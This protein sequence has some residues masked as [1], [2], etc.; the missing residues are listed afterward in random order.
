MAGPRAEREE[1]PEAS[2]GGSLSERSA[3][4]GASAEEDEDA[5]E[6]DDSG[7]QTAARSAAAARRAR[8]KQARWE[9]RQAAAQ[10]PDAAPAVPAE[11]LHRQAAAQ[12]INAAQPAMP[13]PECASGQPITGESAPQR[14]LLDGADEASGNSLEMDSFIEEEEDVSWAEEEKGEEEGAPGAGG[15]SSVACVTADF[16]MQNVLLQMGLRLV[17]PTGARIR[18]LRRWALRCSACFRVTKVGAPTCPGH[19]VFREP[20]E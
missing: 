8:R 12:G 4:E 2:H 20:L 14:E 9:R 19:A 6:D 15:E 18:E 11:P 1:H 17:A 16:A 3:D 10:A 5:S 7:W 13:E